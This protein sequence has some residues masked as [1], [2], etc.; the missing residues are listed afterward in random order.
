MLKLALDAAD[1]TMVKPVC[2][3]ATPGSL[4]VDP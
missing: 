4:E 1:P 3:R 2:L